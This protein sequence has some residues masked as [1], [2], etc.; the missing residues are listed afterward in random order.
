MAHRLGP[1][2]QRPPI[3]YWLRRKHQRLHAAAGTTTPT[4]GSSVQMEATTDRLVMED[5]TS[6]LLL[7]A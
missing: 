6:G 5:G 4:H 2:R 1:R 7:E 3:T